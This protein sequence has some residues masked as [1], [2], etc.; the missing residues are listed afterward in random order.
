MADDINRVM[1]GYN[2]AEQAAEKGEAIVFETEQ[3]AGTRYKLIIS[4]EVENNG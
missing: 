2:R 1:N 4:E 3:V